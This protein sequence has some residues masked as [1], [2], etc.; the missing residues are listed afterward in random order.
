MEVIAVSL[1]LMP[2]FAMIVSFGVL[3]GYAH[4]VCGPCSHVQTRGYP[5]ATRLQN[6]PL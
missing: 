6:E 5:I 2:L 4:C 3:L 1:V